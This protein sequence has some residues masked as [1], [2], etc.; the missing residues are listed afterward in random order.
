MR[1]KVSDAHVCIFLCIMLS[2]YSMIVRVGIML[3]SE[4]V[5]E[6]LPQTMLLYYVDYNNVIDYIDLYRLF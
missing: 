5:Q 4:G 1:F 2:V 3:S 6:M